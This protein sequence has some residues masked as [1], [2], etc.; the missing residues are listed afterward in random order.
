MLK[1]IP[2]QVGGGGCSLSSNIS[3]LCSLEL[4]RRV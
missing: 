1:N 4:G 2:G 3:V